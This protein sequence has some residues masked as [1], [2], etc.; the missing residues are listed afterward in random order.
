MCALG[1]Y[2]PVYLSLSFIS[3]WAGNVFREALTP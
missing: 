2:F 3:S 1:V